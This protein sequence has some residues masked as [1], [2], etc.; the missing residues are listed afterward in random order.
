MGRAI[1]SGFAA[2]GWASVYSD[3]KRIKEAAALLRAQALAFAPEEIGINGSTVDL[4]V[5]GVVMDAATVHGVVSLTVLADGA[6]SFRSN[7]GAAC[8]GYVDELDV[9]WKCSDLLQYAQRFLASAVPTQDLGK[10]RTGD[11]HFY[12]LTQRGAHGVQTSLEELARIDE[13][14]GVLYFAAER[15]IAA[16]EQLCVPRADATA[17][18]SS[19]EGI[20]EFDSDELAVERLETG[21]L[22]IEEDDAQCLS[23]GN[24]APPW[25]T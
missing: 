16:V 25:R 4:E 3:P 5:L 23:A 14:L 13:R 9:R 12:F 19:F 7:D 18:E 15:V 11:V 8:V 20:V 17:S 6:V 24:A 22:D 10:P 21:V 2:S 1:N